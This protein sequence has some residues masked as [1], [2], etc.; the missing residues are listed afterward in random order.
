MIIKTLFTLFITSYFLTGC[1]TS[2]QQTYQGYVEGKNIYLASPFSGRLID[3]FV[4][5]GQH[6]NAKELLFKLDPD[7]QEM[8]NNEASAALEQA[9]KVYIDLTKPKRPEE[10]AAIQAQIGQVNSQIALSA[11]RVKRNQTLYDKHVMDKDTL[12]AAIERHNELGF[13]KAQYEAN[14]SLAKQ[15]SRE[16]QIKAQKSQIALFTSRKNK[17]KWELSQKSIYAPTNGVIFDTYYRKGEFVDAGRAIASLLAPENIRIEFF[18][19]STALAAIHINQ[20]IIFN[21][22]G[23][24]KNNLATIQYISPEAEY[25]PP[26][27]YS[28]NNRDK[29]VFRVKASIPDA[30]RFK[31]GQP[32][33]VTV[34]EHE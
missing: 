29:L 18:I 3:A 2:D 22:D 20:K 12:D 26:L 32:V 6:V 34:V 15:G 1:G 14:L 21:C 25:V 10:I 4:A 28:Q 17:S 8:T 27:V 5:R 13:L 30:A 7:P 16:E 19:P 24:A 11:L 33:M 9:E 31:P 23:C